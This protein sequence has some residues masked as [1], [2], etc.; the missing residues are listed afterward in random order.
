MA[1]KALLQDTNLGA[2][3]AR[4]PIVACRH[5]ETLSHAL[6]LM[7]G[8]NLLSLPVTVGPDIAPPPEAHA[9]VMALL[10][11]IGVQDVLEALI[12]GT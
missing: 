5:N 8:R 4:R 3:V 2:V 12:D 6:E 11:F 7:R 10:G 1:L 9:S